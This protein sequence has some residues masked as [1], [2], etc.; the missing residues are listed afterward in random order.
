MIVLASA[1]PRRKEILERAGIPF[2]VRVS[3]IPE[4]PLPN[5]QPSAHVAR[6]AREKALAVRRDG[7]VVLGADTVVVIDGQILGKPTSPGDAR[8][9]LVLLSGRD[10]YVITGIA[11]AHD[12]GTLTGEAQTTVHFAPL[13]PA[14]IA[15]YVASGE[16]DDKAGAYAIQ[17]LASKF[18][19]RIDGDYFNVVGLPVSLVYRYLRTLDAL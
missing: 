8:R 3:N 9:M 16:P 14:E 5:E 11:V 17:G 18:I 15:A 4:D 19:D 2:T 10:H 7:E 12:G 6:L 13:S 1:S